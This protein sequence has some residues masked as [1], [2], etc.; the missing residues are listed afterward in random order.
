MEW[1]AIV[2]VLAL[3][4]YQFFGFA[5]GGARRKHSIPAPAM[6]GHPDFER[7]VRVHLNT[8]E[9]LILFLPGLWLFVAFVSSSYAGPIAG[10]LGLA[11]IIGRGLYSRGYTRSADARHIGML[12]SFFP[13]VILLLGGLIGAVMKLVS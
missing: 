2:T 4:Q 9:Q 7:V 5:V 12:I 6:A 13:I 3:L 1:A 10:V 8:L 11:F